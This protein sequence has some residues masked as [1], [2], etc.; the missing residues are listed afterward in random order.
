[1]NISTLDKR[2]V[3]ILLIVFVQMVGAG[4]ILPIL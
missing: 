4:M 3:T 1:M 2:L